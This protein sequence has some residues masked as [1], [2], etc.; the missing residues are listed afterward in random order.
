MFLLIN[1]ATS[2]KIQ[3]FGETILRDQ[4]CNFWG[5]IHFLDIALLRATNPDIQLTQPL[6]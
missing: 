6:F 1:V 4:A 3:F 2:I 5:E